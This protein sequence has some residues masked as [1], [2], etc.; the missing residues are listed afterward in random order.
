MDMQEIRANWYED[1]LRRIDE[2]N[3]SPKYSAE[4]KQKAISWLVKQAIK[5]NGED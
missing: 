5:I 3:N 2:V 1:I 4:D